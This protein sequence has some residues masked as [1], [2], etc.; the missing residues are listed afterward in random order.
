LPTIIAPTV[1]SAGPT[2]YGGIEARIGVKNSEM[3]NRKEVKMA[4]TPVRPP[5]DMLHGHQRSS[6]EQ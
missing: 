2:A 3:K 6:P 4:V 1:M 5:A